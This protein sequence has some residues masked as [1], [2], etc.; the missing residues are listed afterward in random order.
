MAE[1]R[2]GSREVAHGFTHGVSGGVLVNSLY[3]PVNGVTAAAAPAP[4]SADAGEEKGA[5]EDK[6]MPDAPYVGCF[7]ALKRRVFG[8]GE[9]EKGEDEEAEEDEEERVSVGYLEILFHNVSRQDVALIVVGAVAAIGTGAAL[10]L[11]T[12]FLG[13]TFNAYNSSGPPPDL[14]PGLTPSSS[15][16]L[17]TVGEQCLN[18][19]YVGV[20]GLVAGSI[21]M[22][23]WMYVG[24]RVTNHIRVSYVRALMRQEVAFYDKEA[25][26]E[27]VMRLTQDVDLVSEAVGEKVGQLLENIAQFVTGIVLGFVRGP[28]LALVIS[29]CIPA[30]AIAAAAMAILVQS[31]ERT[32]KDVYSEGDGIA[33]E[34]L[35]AIRTVVAFTAEP[36]TYDRYEHV[37]WTKT[38]RLIIRSNF[39][40]GLGMG[41]VFFVLFSMYAVAMWYGSVLVR[42]SDYTG[43]EVITVFFAILI[44]GFSLGQAAPNIAA[45]SK[46]VGGASKIFSII[47]REPEMDV[48]GRLGEKL[49]GAGAEGIKSIEFEGVTFAYPTRRDVPIF[50]NLSLSIATGSTTAIVGGSGTG[51][52]TLL[53]LIQRFYDPDAGRVLLNGR[54]LTT[55]DLQDIRRNVFGFVSQ[56]TILFGSMTIYENIAMG[57][58]MRSGAPA[59]GAGED[60]AYADDDPVVV[61]SKRAFAHEFICQLPEGYDTVVGEGGSRISGGQ[62]Q[63]ISIARAMLKRSPILLLDEATSALDAQSENIVQEA[64]DNYAIVGED[65]GE[66]RATVIIVAHRLSTIWEADRIAV[67]DRKLADISAPAAAAGGGAPAPVSGSFVA[68]EGTHVELMKK[69]DG[70]YRQLVQLQMSSSSSSSSSLMSSVFIGRLAAKARRSRLRAASSTG[71]AAGGSR[72][73]GAPGL[74][75]G[76]GTDEASVDIP[77]DGPDGGEEDAAPAGENVYFWRNVYRVFMLSRP[78]WG[79]FFCGI[80]A[81]GLFGC[82]WPVMGLALAEIV[83][84]FYLTD[85][86]KLRNEAQTWSLVFVGLAAGNLIFQSVASYCMGAV[87]GRL[88]SRLRCMMFDSAMHQEIGWHDEDVNNSSA[89]AIRLASDAENV[90]SFLQ[91]QVGLIVQNIVTL[92]VGLTL[93][94]VYSWQLSLVVLGL[95]PLFVVSGYFQFKALAGYSGQTKHLYD[96]AAVMVGDAMDSIRTVASYTLEEYVAMMYSLRLEL[97]LSKGRRAAI[98][99]GISHGCSFFLQ[100]APLALAFYLGAVFVNDGLIS[101]RDSVVVIFVLLYAAMGA[102]QAQAAV[103]DAGRLSVAL[104]N[105][106]DLVDREPEIDSRGGEG[107]DRVLDALRGDVEFRS[108]RFA[109]PTRPE[110]TVFGSLSLL[111][112]SGQ[113][114]AV[115][116]ESGS[117]KSTLLSLILRFYDAGGGSVRIDGADVASLDLGWMRRQIAFVQQEPVLFDTSILENIQYGA[118]EVSEEEAKAAAADANA[119][120][121]ISSFPDGY[122][123]IVGER[124]MQLSGGQKQ[125]IAIARAIVRRPKILLLDEATSALDAESERLVQDA[126][127][128]LRKSRTTIVV[129][130]RLSTVKNADAIAVLK[131]YASP[132]LIPSARDAR[133]G[134]AALLTLPSR[135]THS[136]SLLLHGQGPGHHRDGGGD[137]QLRGGDGHARRADGDRGWRV[138]RARTPAG[139]RDVGLSARQ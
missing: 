103:P 78:D 10:P 86:D 50:S 21:N 40:N 68:E 1:G 128:S 3:N 29:A 83:D 61:A 101:F 77:A 66:Q 69:E 122:D 48:T 95:V 47:R 51:K 110:A 36:R 134:G 90:A 7:M 44:G 117:G 75:D 129:A 130:H 2:S 28:I 17:T 64:L 25:P 16:I 59:R 27:L 18:L 30:L 97:P 118:D 52:S 76:S 121:F 108:V 26:R 53:A 71:S 113:F 60:G 96:D 34:V 99:S 13:D 49:A 33:R 42:E 12:L 46:G 120:A 81:S 11:T 39:V 15:G 115:V 100:I 43:G 135:R 138:Q 63:R 107:A 54:C 73:A 67:L 4:S 19:L 45:I 94:F 93:A 14:P 38:T 55:L 24:E 9:D 41:L 65:G 35:A 109:Y 106:F 105:V 82:V 112:E 124:G 70:V 23:C 31:I 20:A 62:R 137:G 119:H 74:E 136:L 22:F 72:G 80:T 131:R 114:V 116:G 132:A 123:T 102:S 85:M 79:Y 84:V 37:L 6:G 87:T 139:H 111:I 92:V 127:D 57:A 126:L 5:G 88:S 32:K 98:V 56:D 58:A 125:R 104:T 8:G 89:V 91:T 133:R